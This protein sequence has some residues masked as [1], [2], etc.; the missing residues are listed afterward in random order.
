MMRIWSFVAILTTLSFLPSFA[1][2]KSLADEPSLAA[3]SGTA[4]SE[5]FRSK[6]AP[7][8]EQSCVN[9]H[10][11][12]DLKGK[13]SFQSAESFSRG[14]E[15]GPVVTAGK[16][17]KSSLIDY[18][19]G[20]KPEMPKD[21]PPLKK[22][23]VASIA[24]WIESGAKWPAGTTLRSRRE[25][26][27]N[28]WSLLPI[29]RPEIP[30]LSQ[31]DEHWCKTPI[32]RFIMAELRK[33]KLG[34]SPEADRRTLIR[35][36]YFDLT[37]LPPSPEEVAAF[38]ADKD[39]HAYEKHVNQLLASPRYGERW[40]RHWLDVA[41]YG[42]T[43][44]FDKDKLRPN[45]WPYRDYVIRSLNE[46][47]PYSRFVDEQLAGDALYPDSA[48]SIVALGFIAAGPFDYVGQIE[49]AESTTDGQICRNLDRD[50]MV[51]TTMETFTSMTVG[52]AR[53]HDHKF[54]PIKQQDYYS[55]QAVFAAVDRAD[56]PFDANPATARRRASLLAERRKLDDERSD[57]THRQ[58]AAAGAEL[59]RID[60]QLAA[61]KH[62]KVEES[63][64]FGYH[65]AIELH[66]DVDKWVQIDLGKPVDIARLVYVASYDTFNNIGAGFGF[67]V[68]YKIEVGNDAA[69]KR[70]VVLAV[71]RT[72]ADV[73]NPGVAPQSAAV[74]ATARYIRITATRLA[75]RLN[76]FIFALG[77]VMVLTPDGKNA[78]LGATVT[79]LDSIEALPRWSRN[80]LVDGFYHGMGKG[81]PALRSQLEEQRKSLLEKSLDATML[82]RLKE[83]DAGLADV[84]RKLAALPPQ[85]MVYAAAT[86]FKAEGNHR[87]TEGKPREIHVLR[88][89]EI[90]SPAELVGPGAV[91]SIT[92][93]K[94]RFD[95]SGDESQ[96]RA[97]LAAWITDHKNPLTWR[98]I[99]NRVWHYHFG[100]GI[101]DTPNDFGRMGG[102]PSHPE[103]LDW[104]A[105]WFRDDA[106]QSFKELHK[107]IVLSAAYRQASSPSGPAKAA[108]MKAPNDAE[109]SPAKIDAGNRLLWRMNRTKLE[110]EEVRDA[111]LSVAGKLDLTMG[112]PGF[113]DFG[114]KIDHS[115]HYMYD[116]VDPDDARTHRRTIYRFIVRSMP[117]PFLE[118]LDCADPS[119]IV[120]RRN[121]TL[122]ALQSL[123]LL[124]NKFM[125]RMSEH[126]AARV[127]ANVPAKA[128]WPEK[129]DAA[130]R[131]AF[132]RNPSVSERNVLAELASKHGL[133]AACRVI[134]NMNEFV[135]VD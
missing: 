77:E 108:S 29:T 5:L 132:C 34:P 2:N 79:S 32:D 10:N 45:A 66:P 78:A 104:L 52:C 57:I 18:V 51:R 62:A 87:P 1:V 95:A 44:G 92:A 30:R 127:E 63:S 83:L 20:D 8:F 122:T 96:R 16:P 31:S 82:A 98:S 64:S 100:R 99:V 75:P 33:Q 70:N 114:V 21:A 112:G 7:I 67:P 59:K 74:H 15:N 26:D 72:Q 101:V 128:D 61:F 38:V 46:D 54:D 47:K 40:A 39:E 109:F 123:A 43:H 86:D 14:G 97:A 11:D 130:I 58:E 91:A 37:G 22:E 89:G 27:A 76:D 56:R 49:V 113:Q 124:N 53:C 103:L 111:V 65:S 19:S 23:E 42:D 68:R 116:Q 28:W 13:L 84:D 115:P 119:T 126:F 107:M 118:T 125:I 129:I 4:S 24:K 94:G 48:D 55:L 93:L 85:Q 110:A 17:D 35:R 133:P 73:P 50:D 80:N 105:T 69:F 134:F 90:R 120:E 81:D 131:L 135:F 106:G 25:I 6:V 41:H 88:R 60:N 71:D 117:D 12:N 3:K 9:C 102:H 36:L 121:E